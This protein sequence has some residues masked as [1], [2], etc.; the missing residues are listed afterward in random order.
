MR[1][2]QTI[3]PYPA[4]ILMSP[5][6]VSVRG[7]LCLFLVLLVSLP[8]MALLASEPS[9]PATTGSDRASFVSGITGQLF[10]PD[11]LFAPP[12]PS[13]SD[14]GE[15]RVY[16]TDTR[17]KAFTLFAGASEFFT[18]NARFSHE[19]QQGDWFSAL[20]FGATWI[21]R[22]TGNLFAEASVQQQLFRYARFSDL[23][24]NSL[25]VGG[26]LIYVFRDL[27]DLSVFARYNWNL[28]TD[29]TGGGTLFQQQTI[30]LGLQKPFIFSRAHSAVV[31]LQTD[32]NLGGFP[33][34]ALRNRFAFLAGYQANLTR[35]IT[36]SLFYQIAFLPFLDPGRQDWNQILS[37]GLAYAFNKQLSLS[38]SVS[39]SFN[40]SSDSFYTYSVFNTGVAASL[41]L[42]F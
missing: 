42:K 28:L 6:S 41:T 8:G 16:V 17:Y 24:F 26:G 33:A 27:E 9:R 37:A 36:A 10:A 12:S 31:S 38:T 39:A 3:T 15:Q 22:I 5:S 19:G 7:R 32:L 4:F 25:D 1:H 2:T 20:Q 34:Y 11:P 21:P 29:A 30:R 35:N 23:S 18:T 14:L 13:D 40:N